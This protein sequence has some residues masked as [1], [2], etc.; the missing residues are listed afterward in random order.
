MHI[1]WI[2]RELWR[3]RVFVVVVVVFALL[4][5]V[6]VSYSVSFP[7]KL[8]SRR[9]HVGVATAR[10]LVDTPSSQVVEVSPKG[11]D[12]LG[13][14]ANLIASLMVDGVFKSAIARRAGLPTEQL[15]GISQ[16]AAGESQSAGAPP[17][18]GVNVLNTRV[19]PD[20]DG[21]QLPIIQ[22]DTQAS[23]AAGAA[24]LADAAVAGLR[25]YLDSQAA[26]EQVPSARRLRVGGL[27]AAQA[28]EV[29]R[30][31]SLVLASA[32]AIF[33]FISGCALIL[34]VVALIRGW[35]ESALADEWPLE[36]LDDDHTEEPDSDD[37]AAVVRPAVGARSSLSRVR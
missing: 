22:I 24:R 18:R 34:G 12:T 13:V 19:I 10:L 11:S 26:A 23:D 15:V 31:P 29:T 37:V 2:L 6:A 33:V 35:R 4:A 20:L 5:A 1:V 28:S 17:E 36:T 32:V 7:G 14:R 30:G 9:Y 16:N 27:G 21:N 8:E 3:L 25:D